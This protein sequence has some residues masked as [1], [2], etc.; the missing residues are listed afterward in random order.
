MDNVKPTII[1]PVKKKPKPFVAAPKAIHKAIIPTYNA[2]P[3]IAKKI[4]IL[5]PIFPLVLLTNS[6]LVGISGSDA[7]I[8]IDTGY[9]D[10]LYA[11][12]GAIGDKSSQIYLYSGLYAT[13]TLYHDGATSNLY[14]KNIQTKSLASG[15]YFWKGYLSGQYAHDTVTLVGTPDYITLNNQEI[16]RHKLDLSDDTNFIEG[17]GINLNINTVS[18]LGYNSISSNAHKAYASSQL[19][20]DLAFKSQLDDNS[21]TQSMLKSGSEYWKG[22]LSGQNAV[23][24][25]FADA[26][27]YPSSLGHSLNISYISHSGNYSIHYPSS[28]IV[29]WFNTLYSPTGALKKEDADSYYFPS[30]LGSNLN[31]SYIGHSSNSTIH[32]TKSS[33]NDDYAPSSLTKTRYNE[34]LGHSGQT[35]KHIDHSTVNINS[36]VGLGGGGDITA[37]RTLSVLGYT[38]ISSQAKLGYQHINSTG[39]DHTYINQSVTTDSTPTFS[40]LRL[41]GAALYYENR[42]ITELRQLVDKDYVD[43][44]VSLLGARFFMLDTDSGIEDY[45]L[46]QLD[47]PEESEESVTIE[48]VTDGQ[49]L[50]GWIS[51]SP[52]LLSKLI[53]G[54]YAWNITA[55]KTNGTKDLRIFWELVERK[56][57]DSEVVIGTSNYSNLITDKESF[58]ITL[59]LANDYELSSNSYVVGKIYANVVGGGSSPTIKIYYLGKINSYWEIPSHSDIFDAQYVNRDGDTMTGNLTA[60][61]FIATN[62][63]VS[64]NA[65]SGGI[66]KGTWAGN[67]ITDEYIANDITLSNITQITNRSHTDLTDIGSYSHSQIDSHIDDSTIHFTQS[68]LNDDYFPSSLG[69]SHI[70]NI[71][72]PHSVTASQVGNTTA[73]WNADKEHWIAAEDANA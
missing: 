19:L 27:Y 26:N 24:H 49:Y 60:P 13:K 54:I 11:K 34:Y 9:L 20:K 35:N 16:T 70:N 8:S 67:I 10:T 58:I 28:S 17:T 37:S 65:I 12:S 73:Q 42:T 69:H 5:R 3:I 31:L 39:V 41:S 40:G 62:S 50:I 46:T 61:G 59:S 22:Y 33:L 2:K 47:E 53:Q 45:K 7:T 25:I 71:S 68:S 1:G 6:F 36:G 4:S 43:L 52:G 66:I 23:T 48:N 29:P 57:D 14:L 32:F 15:S 30:S 64:S 63:G 44:A 18:V 38:T 55:E 21:V 51:P 56:S 72:N